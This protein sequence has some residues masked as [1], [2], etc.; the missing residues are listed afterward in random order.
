MRE[1]LDF[2]S[3]AG[4]EV[5]QKLVESNE[6]WGLYPKLAYIYEMDGMF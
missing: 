2:L 4:S 5:L 6:N 1:A 3:T